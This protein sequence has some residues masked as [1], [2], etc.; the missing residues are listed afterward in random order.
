[1]CAER[2]IEGNGECVIALLY[3]LLSYPP[4]LEVIVSIERR[5]ATE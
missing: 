3:T 2:E 1:V 4:G 5:G